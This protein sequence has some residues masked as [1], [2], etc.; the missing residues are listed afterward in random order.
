MQ[1]LLLKEQRANSVMSFFL[2]IKCEAGQ[3]QKLLDVLLNTVCD[4]CNFS[5]L[6]ELNHTIE[7]NV[8]SLK[9]FH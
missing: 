3:S 7:T 8:F 9:C 6:A 5:T 1:W 4:I 2:P